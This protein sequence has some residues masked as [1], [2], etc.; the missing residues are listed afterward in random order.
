M[1][2]VIYFATSVEAKK[3]EFVDFLAGRAPD[4]PITNNV[5]THDYSKPP[6]AIVFGRGYDYNDVV[7]L[8]KKSRGARSA[9]VAWIAG[10]PNVEPPT[11]LPP[12]YA[13][14]AA[15]NVKVY[16]HCRSYQQNLI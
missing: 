10:D 13:V 9:P 3:I 4:L 16:V 6:Q 2:V 12:D 7:E 8:N 11:P 1:V 15:A 14:Q 5:G